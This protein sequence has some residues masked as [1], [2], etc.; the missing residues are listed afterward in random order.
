MVTVVEHRIRTKLST[1]D[2]GIA[3]RDYI[4]QRAPGAIGFT[5]SRKLAWRFSTPTEDANPFAAI[6]RQDAPEF[7]VAAHFSLRKRPILANDAQVAAWDG[8]ISLDVWEKE[9]YRIALISCLD[10]PGPK[11]QVRLVLDQLK[12]ADPAAEIEVS[13]TKLR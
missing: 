4:P 2:I 12:T 9:S 11:A 8:S 13:R 10:G 7:R 6:E 5:W 1:A 3:F